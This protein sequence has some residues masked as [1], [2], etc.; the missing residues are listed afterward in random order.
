MTL[1][2]IYSAFA[3]IAENVLQIPQFDDTISMATTPSWD[4]LRHVQLLSAVEKKFGIEI[5]TR[6]VFRLTS[7]EA[8]VLYVQN[9]IEKGSQP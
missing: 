6:D 5:R 2:E 3:P 9:A 8:L 1:Q 7:A 4:S